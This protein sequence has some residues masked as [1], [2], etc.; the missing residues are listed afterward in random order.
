MPS[1]RQSRPLC[2][3]TTKQGGTCQNYADSCRSF[4]DRWLFVY[5][6]PLNGLGGPVPLATVPVR[7]LWRTRV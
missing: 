7:P 1:E 4:L 5:L 2:A 3:V 6:G